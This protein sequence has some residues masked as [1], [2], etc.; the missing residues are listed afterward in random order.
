MFSYTS[1][2]GKQ[3]ALPM[4]TDAYGLYYNTDMFAEAGIIDAAEDHSPSW[5]T[6]PRS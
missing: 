3:C 6:W 5:P 4:L 2:E 1:F